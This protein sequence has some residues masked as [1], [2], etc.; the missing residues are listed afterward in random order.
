[1]STYSEPGI[2]NVLD[3]W[4]YDGVGYV[5]MIANEPSPAIAQ[6]NAAVLQA[7]VY[8][9]QAASPSA[10]PQAPPSFAATI[11][12]PGHSLVPPPVG[13][14]SGTD[15]G[16]EYFIQVPSG[17][18]AAIFVECNWPLR[19][20]GTG[21]VKLTMVI[22]ESQVP[23]DM[24]SLTTNTGADANIGGITFEDLHLS[25]QTIT[26]TPPPQYAAIHTLGAGA[27]NVRI[28]R[29]VLDDCPIGVWFE[30]ALQCS[31]LQCTARY[32]SNVGTCVMLG[33]GQNEG[34]NSTAKE[35]YIAGCVFG[36]NKSAPR[37]S[38]G[39]WMLGSEHV[40]VSDTRLDGFTPGILI[41]PGP[42][43]SNAV[44]H[45]FTDV[46]AYASAIN[47][48]GGPEAGMASVIQP[49]SV[50]QQIGHISFVSCFFG[51][52]DDSSLTMSEGA[53][54]LINN[55]GSIIDTVRFVSCY[56]CRWSG[57]GLL[58]SYSGE[59]NASKLQNIEILGGMYAGNN[60]FPG[61]QNS[62]QP[63]GIAV[64]G[65][66]NK[67]RIVGAS[68]VGTYQY[69]EIGNVHESPQQQVGIYVDQGAQNVIVDGCDL[70][71][72][73][74]NG[75]QVTGESGSVTTG[76]FIRNCNISDQ[77][78]FADAVNVGPGQY[79]SDVEVTN[80]SGYNDQTAPITTAV[81]SSP[82]SAV[83]Y[84]YYGPVTFYG[85]GSADLTVDIGGHT[86]D[87]GNGTF[88]LGPGVSA[89][90]FVLVGGH[91]W[92]NFLMVGA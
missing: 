89:A 24:F 1:M 57:P 41:A 52:G 68:C 80:C 86:T 48:V 44:H 64:I 26:T 55:N 59:G 82:F 5:G 78:T 53:G 66:A 70:T 31:I 87:L 74:Q 25:Y 72:N 71:G 23:G 20:L 56:S 22:P 67:I 65:A 6:Q 4:Y 92:T 27:Q 28:V 90:F 75:A 18:S 81:P 63:Y 85:S 76:V 88:V 60:L 45:S 8:L 73:E 2:F 15:E 39:I 32:D 29:V 84:G 12:F 30:E 17:A 34:D 43:G 33:D 62:P 54:V 61:G 50:S 36:V 7:I 13:D 35:I 69:V 9:A 91:V 10:C 42:Y 40:R 3:P 51:P 11:L 16:A 37:G 77:P 47:E 21:N 38:I 46:S 58:I 79:V 19:F 14:G 49:Q 83:T